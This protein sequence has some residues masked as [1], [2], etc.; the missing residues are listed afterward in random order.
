MLRLPEA[1]TYSDAGIVSRTVLSAD[2]MR[3]VL[4]SFAPGQELTEHTTPSR[5]LI[6]ALEGAADVT[7]SGTL[8]A[9]KPGDLL[10]MPPGAP[11]AVAA[12]E[13]FAMLLVMQKPA[14]G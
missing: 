5:A 4:F 9:L 12:R 14:A 11:H 13:R 3:V 8:H 6:M 1:N 2:G 10:H 7:V